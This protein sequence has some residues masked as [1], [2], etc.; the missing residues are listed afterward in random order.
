LAIDICR[1]MIA[2]ATM[3]P[4]AAGDEVYGRSSQLRKFLQDNEIGYVMRVGCAFHVTIAPAVTGRADT[5]V[6]RYAEPDGD[7]WQ[8]CSVAGSKGESLTNGS[9][10][11]ATRCA[12]RCASCGGG[13][14]APHMAGIAQTPSAGRDADRGARCGSGQAEVAGLTFEQPNPG[15]DH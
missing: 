8:V 4:W 7:A 9:T 15:A 6:A 2:D 10:G 14:S 5:V 12:R 11:Y 3:P 13:K 1:D